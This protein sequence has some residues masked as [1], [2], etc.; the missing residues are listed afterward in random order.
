MRG[1]VLLTLLTVTL[2][3]SVS[4]AEEDSMSVRLALCCGWTQLDPDAYGGWKGECPGCDVEEFQCI[5]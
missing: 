1:L 5:A 3:P 4:L 2:M